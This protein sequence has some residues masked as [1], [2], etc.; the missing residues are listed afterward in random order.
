MAEGNACACLRLNGTRRPES[1]PGDRS[2]TSLNFRLSE[3]QMYS[4]FCSPNSDVGEGAPAKQWGREREGGL[5]A[6]LAAA[7]QLF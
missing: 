4:A 6:A 1:G 2:V 3:A 7:P 5:W